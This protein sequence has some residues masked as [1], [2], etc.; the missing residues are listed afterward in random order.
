MKARTDT[1][2][3]IARQGRAYAV[4]PMGAKGVSCSQ[5]VEIVAPDGA[6]CGAT[7]FPIAS[8]TCD[9]HDLVLGADGTVIQQL[10]DAMETKDEIHAF[11]TCTWRWWAGSAK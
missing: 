9:T 4:L 6:S 2:L 7:D 1:R 3:Q 5:R 10:P 11:H 8:G